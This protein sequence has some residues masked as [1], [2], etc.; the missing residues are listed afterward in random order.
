MNL[1]NVK[2][3][4]VYKNYGELCAALGEDKKYGDSKVAQLKK[5]SKRFDW[6]KDGHKFIITNF[7][8][9]GE[10][11]S[12]Q[13]FV[14]KF[15]TDKQ[16]E[17]YSSSKMNSALRSTILNEANRHCD[18]EYDKKK[19]IYV[20]NR[21]YKYPVPKKIA[22]MKKGIYEYM[23]P[24]LLLHIKKCYLNK[25]GV[26]VSTRHLARKIAI[27]NMNYD[28][29]RKNSL[30]ICSARFKNLDLSVNDIKISGDYFNYFDYFQKVDQYVT[31]YMEHCLSL[32]QTAKAIRYQK[33]DK[34]I[35][36]VKNTTKFMLND[37]YDG[38]VFNK[39]LYVGDHKEVHIRRATKSEID[40]I[41]N[42]E[43]EADNLVGLDGNFGVRDRYYGA[44]ANLWKEFYQNL[45]S[46]YCKDKDYEILGLCSF[47]EIFAGSEERC[48][49]YLQY[50]DY[51]DEDEL[52][53]NFVTEFINLIMT[54]ANDRYK[55]RKHNYN[56]DYLLNFD[57]LTK[58][59]I[60]DFED[61]NDLISNNLADPKLEVHY[62]AT[63]KV[64]F[65]D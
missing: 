59:T 44:K 50:F 37:V 27:Y 14:E 21:Y 45:M 7:T 51:K 22:L 38:D 15:G 33:I 39:N 8:S 29:M 5:W 26:N 48:D 3:G 4:N 16:K 57:N 61:I 35:Y 60:G 11:L 41:I 49:Q 6:K 18:I 63:N 52:H 24:S 64:V 1:E 54:K 10:I 42:I 30:E 13:D 58:I 53:I 28:I 46:E 40:A 43:S 19:K 32:L 65:D 36:K 34:L 12:E 2:I 62:V 56:E 23:I 9:S 55:N 20:V 17:K 31:Y 25:D 47:Y